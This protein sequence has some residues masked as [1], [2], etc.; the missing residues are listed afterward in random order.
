MNATLIK[1]A[2]RLR[3]RFNTWKHS[4]VLEDGLPLGDKE[5]KALKKDVAVVHAFLSKI[6]PHAPEAG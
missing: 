3:T 2:A 6:A 1:R 4:A 5:R